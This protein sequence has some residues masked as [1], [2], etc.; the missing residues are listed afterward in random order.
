MDPAQAVLKDVPFFEAA[1]RN[2]YNRTISP[3]WNGSDHR[4]FDDA[5]PVR[6]PILGKDKRGQ[7]NAANRLNRNPIGHLRNGLRESATADDVVSNL[8]LGFWAHM[9]DRSHERALW[10]PSA[11]KAWPKGTPRNDVN[12]RIA[13]INKV[14]N[15]AAHHE[16]LFASPG[17]ACVT[18]QS[19][20]E[21]LR[22]SRSSNQSHAATST[23][24]MSPNARSTTIW[25]KT[26]RLAMLR[27]NSPCMHNPSRAFHFKPPSQTS[28]TPRDDDAT[29]N[30]TNHSRCIP[31]IANQKPDSPESCTSHPLFRQLIQR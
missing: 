3:T 1:L 8:T 30:S 17:C 27:S 9:T 5:S 23:A 28:R 20:R 22:C 2:A 4:L 10:I 7:V 13:R 12:N 29:R 14:R 21:P 26:R 31:E 19:C 16:H 15:R 18:Q 24:G 6:R 25:K 11:H